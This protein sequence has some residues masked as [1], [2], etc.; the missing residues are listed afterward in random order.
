V[1]FVSLVLPAD[2]GMFEA[3]PTPSVYV[4]DDVLG[5]SGDWNLSDV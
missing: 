5:R 2:P 3:T 4:I 1:V